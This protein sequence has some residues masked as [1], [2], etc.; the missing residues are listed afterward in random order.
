MRILWRK[1][2]IEGNLN[3]PGWAWRGARVISSNWLKK[4]EEKR[5]GHFTSVLCNL[6]SVIKM[7]KQ[8]V[9]KKTINR[10]NIVG[11][12]RTSGIASWVMGRVGPPPSEMSRTT[13]HSSHSCST[14]VLM[15]P[16][17]WGRER[18]GGK[19]GGW[20][21]KEGEAKGWETCSLE[22]KEQ[23]PPHNGKHSSL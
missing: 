7:K 13:E 5:A 15:S 14:L 22:T 8:K 23:L 1:K 21:E 19:E 9:A 2:Q 3:D 20:G 16:P 18:G 17:G 10:R 6:P 11:C 12:H 4:N